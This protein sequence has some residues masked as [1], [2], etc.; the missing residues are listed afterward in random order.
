MLSFLFTLVNNNNNLLRCWHLFTNSN[1]DHRGIEW[2]KTFLLGIICSNLLPF[3]LLTLLTILHLSI[4]IIPWDFKVQIY[5]ESSLHFSYF[6]CLKSWF[7]NLSLNGVSEALR[8]LLH[9]LLVLLKT[10]A[11]CTILSVR[12]LRKINK[13]NKL[14]KFK[15]NLI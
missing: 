5:F 14:N 9:L 11:S 1:F 2:C 12:H 13:F 8:Y 7:L 6:L 3:F 10:F 4:G 15:F